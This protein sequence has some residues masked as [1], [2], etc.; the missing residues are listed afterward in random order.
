MHACARKFLH[1]FPL[2]ACKTAWRHPSGAGCGVGDQDQ[3]VRS[4]R[5]VRARQSVELSERPVTIRRFDLLV[6]R[7][8]KADGVG[9]GD[10][11]VVSSPH[12]ALTFARWLGIW[13]PLLGS[14]GQHCLGRASARSP[15][16]MLKRWRMPSGGL[17]SC[18]WLGVAR[19]SFRTL[20]FNETQAGQTERSAAGR[21]DLA[22]QND[23]IT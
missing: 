14:P 7:E 20:T 3:R 1:D 4:Y 19:S 9:C 18:R 8:L 12:R 5:R 17:G 21:R 2:F 22:R 15:W 13:V 6:R 23:S 16:T 10:L 11:S